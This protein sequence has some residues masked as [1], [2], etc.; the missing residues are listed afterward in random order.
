MANTSTPIFAVGTYSQI[1]PAIE[2]GKLT[3]PS[4]V[5]CTDTGTLVFVDK[6]LEMQ[7]VKG[8]GQTSILQVDTLP[9]GADAEENTFYFCD[10]VGYLYIDGEAVPLL[11][12]TTYDSL[13][14][15]PILNRYGDTGATIV[16]AELDNGCYSVS[17]QYQ[18]TE[19][20][21]IYITARKV[22]FLVDSDTGY[23][24]ITKFGTGEILL[25]AVDQSTGDMTETSYATQAWVEAQGYVTENYVTEAIEELYEKI[26]AELVIPT[27]VSE[28]ENDAGYLTASDFDGI[29]STEINGLFTA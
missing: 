14:D 13:E 15:A 9:D 10:G 22:L 8:Y 29:S 19:E 11:Q 24:Y 20:D 17:G 28:L 18:I 3:Y 6:N 5:F 25:Y 1:Q 16:L 12:D 2:S 23:T 21:T 27:K 7:D 4:Y 26:I